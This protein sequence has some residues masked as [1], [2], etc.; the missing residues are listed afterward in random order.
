M[1][2]TFRVSWP[3]LPD[4]D[5]IAPYLR[6]IDEN[7]YYSN[8][9]PLVS[10]LEER[11][12]ERLGLSEKCV[13]TVSNATTGLIAALAAKVKD[14]QRNVN[15]GP[16]YCL[17][18]SWTFV[19]T[20]HAVLAVGL[21]PYLV[22]VD[23]D[24]WALTP[25]RAEEAMSHVPG[26]PVAVVPVCPFGRPVDMAEWDDFAARTGLTVVV[27]AAAGFDKATAGASL[28]VV[29]LHAT[30]VLAAGEGGYV[31]STDIDLI[32]EVRKCI[33]FGFLGSRVAMSRAINGKMSEYHAAVA[34]AALDRWPETRA[35]FG[36]V[37]E[38]YRAETRPDNQI[39]IVP[40]DGDD[41]VTS[42]IMM[43]HEDYLTEEFETR[44][45]EL[46]VETRRWWGGGVHHQIAYR[47]FSRDP[48][49]NTAE[50]AGHTIGLPCHPDLTAE[51]IAEICRRVRQALAPA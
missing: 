48:L 13:V 42:T 45:Q 2:E 25:E 29:S 35:V 1:T 5:A 23:A 39:S 51:D 50:L 8:F 49:P 32:K 9:G 36:R 11:L 21:E 15:D 20:L 40:G 10:E 28:S 43:Q 6:R 31:V 37:A 12:A 38:L 18:P 3:K 27:D 46:G 16:A 47:R 4:I 17:M 33:N 41:F 26:Q 14:T 44:L 34:H 24:S 19:A 30:K 7:R 22:D